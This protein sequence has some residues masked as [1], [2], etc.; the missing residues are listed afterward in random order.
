METGDQERRLGSIDF[1][2]DKECRTYNLEKSRTSGSKKRET[3]GSEKG[4]AHTTN[5]IMESRGLSRYQKMRLPEMEEEG[6]GRER[7]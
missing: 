3:S 6:G 5:G 7:Q 1:G 2:G 4:K